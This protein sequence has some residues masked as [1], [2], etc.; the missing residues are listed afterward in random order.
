M[1]TEAVRATRE[2]STALAQHKQWLVT[3]GDEIGKAAKGTKEWVSQA[4]GIWEAARTETEPKVL[5][6]L[7]RYQY[8]RNQKNWARPVFDSLQQELERC[9]EKAAG[10]DLLAL[11]LMRHLM[12]YT[13]RSFTYHNKTDKAANGAGEAN[14]AAEV[15]P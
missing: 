14:G 6:N 7:L 11:D 15:R 4:R 9:I 12:V 1:T 3:S 5:L 2:R 13:I 8:A 10:D